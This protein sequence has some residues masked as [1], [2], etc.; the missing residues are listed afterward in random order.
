MAHCDGVAGVARML[1]RDERTI[2]DWLSGRK[3]VP[4][5]VPELM[6]L[7]R[8]EADVSARRNG[9]RLEMPLAVVTHA[10]QLEI[11]RQDANK[12]QPMTAL[13]LVDFDPVDPVISSY[14]A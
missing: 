1:R 9:Y 4:F 6:R 11:R 14:G 7:R 3:R 8:F 2:R 12:P 13:R 10:A 5:W